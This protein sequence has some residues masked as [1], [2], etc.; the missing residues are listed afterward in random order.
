MSNPKR[1]KIVVADGYTT[2]PGDLD[3]SSLEALGE[4]SVFERC[5]AEQ[6]LAR[7]EHA[8]I[9]LTNKEVFDRATLLQLPRLSFIS[10]LATGTNVVDL[11]A[12]K[13]RGVKV[14]NVP[15]YSTHSV[16]EHTFALLF[17]LNNRV[18]EHNRAARDGTWTNSGHFSFRTG[19]IH[20][21]HGGCFG[22]VG[23][24]TI[25]KRVAAV[26]H[27]LGMRVLAA[28]SLNPRATGGSGA[29]A[30]PSFVARAPLEQVL[31]D[32]DVLSLHCPLSEATRALL[33]RERLALMKPTSVLLNTGRGALLDELALAD[34]L[35]SGALRGAALDVLNQEPPPHAHPLLSAPNCIVTPHLAW[36][37][38][39]A[40]RRLLETSVANVRAFLAGKPQNLVSEG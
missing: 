24:G 21:L 35:N 30:D 11:V 1:P 22:I 14:S 33:N 36:A 26:A 13:E 4:L 16:V 25:G 15:A 39:A 31:R 2:N 9:V 29:P 40:R 19:P 32:A 8:D 5:G 17:A 7:C 34:A 23:L 38:V 28:E 10:V 37:T 18:D 20:E 27:A 12:A 3:W 6:L